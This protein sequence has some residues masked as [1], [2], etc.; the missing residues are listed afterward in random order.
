MLLDLKLLLNAIVKK[1]GK[2]SV[3]NYFTL[4]KAKAI[5]GYQVSLKQ[6]TE[7]SENAIQLR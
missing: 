1:E 4:K 3:V 5:F 7:S 6:L 2:G